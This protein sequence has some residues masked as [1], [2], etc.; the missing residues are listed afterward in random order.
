MHRV[1]A[2]LPLVTA[3]SSNLYCATYATYAAYQN[4]LCTV[5]DKLKQAQAQYWKGN[6]AKL[7]R[8][9]HGAKFTPYLAMLPWPVKEKSTLF[10]TQCRR[11]AIV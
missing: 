10:N 3:T 2:S 7:A 8:S 11:D 4:S 9:R 5:Y 6:R 1:Y